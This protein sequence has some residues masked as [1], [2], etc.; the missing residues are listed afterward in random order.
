M[1]YLSDFNKGSVGICCKRKIDLKNR[2]IITHL[3]VTQNSKLQVAQLLLTN[4]I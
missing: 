3:L 2:E 4:P 1:L